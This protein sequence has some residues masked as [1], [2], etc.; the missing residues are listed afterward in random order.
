[1]SNGLQNAVP[2]LPTKVLQAIVGAHN[3]GKRFGHTWNDCIFGEAVRYETAYVCSNS[4]AVIQ[5]FDFNDREQA[6]F[7]QIY[8]NW[9]AK[10]FTQNE[11]MDAV[12]QELT[13][14][15]EGGFASADA[16]HLY[17]PLGR[18]VSESTKVKFAGTKIDTPGISDKDIYEWISSFQDNDSPQQTEL[19]LV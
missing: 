7:V 6:A 8:T 15:I 3:T 17:K 10:L 18:I 19:H 1:M 16:P 14:R 5:T 13:K 4:G 9:D 11:L 12:S 2:T